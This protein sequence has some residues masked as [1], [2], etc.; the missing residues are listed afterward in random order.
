MISQI[1][2]CLCLISITLAAPAVVPL[3]N[4]TD[5][6]PINITDW[7]KNG[8]FEGDL[9]LSKEFILDHYNFSSVPG[10]EKLRNLFVDGSNSLKRIERRGVGREGAIKLWANGIVRYRISDHI[11]ESTATVEVIRRAINHWEHHTC[12]RFEIANS[13]DYIEFVNTSEGCH[14]TSIGRKGGKQEINLESGGCES[15]GIIVHE[16]GHAIGFWHEQSRPDRGQYVT[17]HWDNIIESNKAHYQFM[18]REVNEIHSFGSIYD[19]GSIMHYGETYFKKP[20]CSGCTTISV[21]NQ[22]EYNRQGTPDIGQRIQLST[23]D[24][25]QA[26][27]LYACYTMNLQVYIRYARN[28]RDTDPWLNDPDPYVRVQARRSSG[29]VVTQSTRDIPG[30]TN[31]TWNQWLNFGCQKWKNF[32]MQVWDDD[33]FRDDKMSNKELILMSLGN[34]YSQKH[35]A[36]DSGYLYYDYKLI[37]DIND[38]IPNRCRNGGT[39]IDQCA[40]Y[41]CSCRQG[42]AGTNCEY[43]AGNLLVNARYGRNLPDKDG[44]LNKSDPYMEFIAVDRFGNSRRLTTSVRSGTH[45]PNWD[46]SLNFGYRAWRYF[47]VRVYD[48]DNNADDAMSSSETY[49]LPSPNYSRS[50]NSHTCYSGN[51]VFGYSYTN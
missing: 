27:L 34:Q 36:Y 21:K 28:L 22:A 7:M 24:I 14:S 40:S 43:R 11:S 33:I 4:N 41:R 9:K 46:Q 20:N 45:N 31:P 50:Y 15:F 26:N 6:V 25:K 30:T 12:L 44:W 51:T 48:S 19:Y 17:I 49:W 18:S 1:S 42:Y 8:L 23:E 37:R 47:R 10:G 39:C 38:C 16:I 5:A 2:V 3:K 35:N 32:E 29:Y 13:G